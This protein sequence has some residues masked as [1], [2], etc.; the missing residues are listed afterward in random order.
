MSGSI[1][2]L[3]TV[4]AIIISPERWTLPSTSSTVGHCYHRRPL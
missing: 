3:M 1:V 4:V 2:Q